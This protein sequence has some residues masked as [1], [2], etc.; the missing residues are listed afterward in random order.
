MTGPDRPSATAILAPEDARPEEAG[1]ED[2]ALLAFSL[3]P[4][5]YA[6]ELTRAREIVRW[7][8]PTPLPGVPVFVEGVISVRGSVLPVI[9]LGRRIG[10][11]PSAPDPTQRFVIVLSR[12]GE[13][14]ALRVDRVLGV[15]RLLAGDLRPPVTP[16][17]MVRAVAAEAEL[18]RVLDVEAVLGWR[19]DGHG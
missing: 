6:V 2:L 9:D 8:R 15:L 11:P 3:G 4:R 19:E 17:P 14:A 18:T 1:G 12:L 10:L 16:E 7:R 13:P 5:H